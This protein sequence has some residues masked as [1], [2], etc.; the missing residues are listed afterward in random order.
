MRALQFKVFRAVTAVASLAAVAF[1]L[2]A[3]ADPP[4]PCFNHADGALCND[5]NPCTT[6]DI[7]ADGW[8]RG[9]V[10]PNGTDCTDGNLCTVMDRCVLGLCVGQIVPEGAA[11]DDGNKCT[12]GERCTQGLCVPQGNLQCNDNNL[13]TQDL[14]L[15]AQGCVFNVVPMCM[16]PD[17]GSGGSGGQ[18]GGGGGA[19]GQGGQGGSSDAG[20][21]ATTDVA[22]PDADVPLDGPADVA[23][24]PDAGVPDAPTDAPSELIEYKVEGGALLCSMNAHPPGRP[25]AVTWLALVALFTFGIVR[26]RRRR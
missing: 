15:P 12:T 16:V 9:N 4:D 19:G 7:C 6:N 22:S 18:G 10:A 2:S 13:C 23:A 5:G 25:G 1:P 26:A 8:C 14:C 3:A 17:A 20:F 11:C 24:A 21:D